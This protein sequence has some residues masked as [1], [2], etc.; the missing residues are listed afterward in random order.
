M[1][2]Q[3][4]ERLKVVQSINMPQ[5]VIAQN[6]FYFKCVFQDSQDEGDVVDN[7]E[8]WIETL[9]TGI[10]GSVSNECTM[11]TM[12]VYEYDGASEDWDL[13]GEASPTVTFGATAEML[14]HG[15]CMVVRAY[16]TDPDVIGRKYI[17]GFTEDLSADGAWT[18][19]GLADA[20]GFGD[21]WDNTRSIDAN[22]SL[23]PGVFST[24]YL[25]VIQLNGTE[26]VLANPGYQRRRR[27]G[28][29]I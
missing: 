24:R 29:G 14:P 12:L 26:V 7:L 28:V 13:I 25:D 22:N 17:P 20:A 18:A 21:D 8:I 16:T 6:V 27:P 23:E 1:A 10:N 9:Y 11:G 5:N 2:V 4:G 15:V 3:N 19:G